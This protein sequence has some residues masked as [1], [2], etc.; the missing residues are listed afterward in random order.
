[1]NVEKTDKVVHLKKW[2]L[3]LV[4]PDGKE[5]IMFYKT[6]GPLRNGSYLSEEINSMQLLLNSFLGS[7]SINGE[8]KLKIRQSFD[9]G[10]TKI[11]GWKII[12]RGH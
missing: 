6:N 3:H 2:D 9:D 12:I 1:M 11:K 10:I 4:S 5:G 7:S 8:W